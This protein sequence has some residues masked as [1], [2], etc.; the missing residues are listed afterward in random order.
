M[1]SEP[2]NS[3]P[4]SCRLAISLVRYG[5]LSPIRG[6]IK[7]I[8]SSD[9][10][11]SVCILVADNGPDVS[12][13]LAEMHSAGLIDALLT[14]THNPG[15]FP[16]AFA[17][18][19]EEMGAGT[20][21][22][23]VAN[24]DLGFDLADAVR[25]LALRRAD[26]PQVVAPQ[27]F[28]A[29]S[30]QKNPHIIARPSL[31]WFTVRATV[32]S[33]YV[34][35]WLFMWLHRRKASRH[36]TPAQVALGADMYAPHGSIVAISNAAFRLLEPQSHQAVLYSEEIWLGEQCYVHRIPIHLADEWGVEHQC[37]ASTGALSNRAR[38]RLWRRASL[39]SLGLRLRSSRDA[40][41]RG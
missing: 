37:H 6:L 10:R 35:H 19:R 29:G 9:A 1:N 8:N 38:H 36:S 25:T 34:T 33:N 41:G 40:G 27:V 16:S 23:I 12:G 21:W 28:E 14:A 31:V 2:V 18:L 20:D 5:D 3:E 30:P 39:R 24:P 4:D 11:A 22:A 32:H 17:S 7:S 26:V 15:Y 13:E